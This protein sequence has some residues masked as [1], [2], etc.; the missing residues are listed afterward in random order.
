MPIEINHVA[1]PRGFAS[2][3]G[4][5]NK[6]LKINCILKEYG[7]MKERTTLL[8]IGTGNGEIASYLSEFYD[9]VSVD[10]TDQRTVC[11]GFTF[12]Q[13]GG[14]GLPFSDKSFDVVVSNHVIEHVADADQHLSEIERVLKEGGLAYLAT[15][16]RFWPWEVHNEIP[17]LHYLPTAT[18]NSVLKRLGR[19]YEDFFPLTWWALSRKAEKYFSV[20]IVSDRICK[21]PLQYHMPCYPL[22][23]RILSWIP[24]RF[25]RMCTFIHPTLV[26]VL[27]SKR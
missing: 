23:A 13:L 18:F 20:N 25:Y 6:S 16:N 2:N 24:L 27:K 21:W 4:R 7:G 9:V 3:V 12:V 26:V 5:L 10:I 8:D 22:A 15:P 17:L 1:H 11:D 14:E 19:H